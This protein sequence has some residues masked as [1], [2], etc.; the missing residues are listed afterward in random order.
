MSTSPE[1]AKGYKFERDA[2]KAVEAI[3]KGGQLQA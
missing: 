3:N 1:D 2:R